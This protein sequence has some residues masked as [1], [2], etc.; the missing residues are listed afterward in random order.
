[1]NTVLPTP[2]EIATRYLAAWNAT[3]PQRRRALV[4]EAFAD[5]ATYV[6]PMAEVAGHDGLDALIAGVQQHYPGAHFH[7]HGEPQGHHDRVRFSWALT[8]NGVTG[9]VAHGTD[10]A[11][12][13]GDGRLHSVTGFLDNVAA[14]GA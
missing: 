3:D 7:L 2:T 12:L 1:M 5:G 6:D 9:P 14:T 8:V 13:A 4:R 10:V 11:V